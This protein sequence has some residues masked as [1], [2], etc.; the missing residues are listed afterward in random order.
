MRFREFKTEA[1]SFSDDP[2]DI[3][4]S[5]MS[6][7]LGEPEPGQ[8]VA[9]SKTN[10]NTPSGTVGNA[11]VNPT[12]ATHAASNDELKNIQDPDFNKKLKK[13]ADTL[14][15]NVNDL[16][17]IIHNES[18]GK[19]SAVY[20]NKKTGFRAGGLIGFTEDTCRALGTSLDA[21]LKMSAVDQ[22]DYVL[23]YYRM[24]GVK[25]NMNRGD[26]YMLTF[27]PA[28]KHASDST[29]LGR[30]GGGKLPGT[31]L[32]MDAIWRQ[33]AGFSGGHRKDY[34]TVGDVKDNV[35]RVA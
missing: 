17:A 11:P 19:P 13:V 2:S 5:T 23:K 31:N 7:I 32:S 25:P 8:E 6:S 15:I 1:F 26:I 34:F 33:N 20:T 12:P 10:P 35:N 22:L 4:S 30:K 18:R 16:K 27:M 29:V 28:Y 21:I 3:S 24:V 14:G 9:T